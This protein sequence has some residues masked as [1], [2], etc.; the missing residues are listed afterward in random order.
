MRRRLFLSLNHFCERKKKSWSLAALKSLSMQTVSLFYYFD[1]IES[2]CDLQVSDFQT[3]QKST[4]TFFD[5]FVY[6]SSIDTDRFHAMICNIFKLFVQT[7]STFFHR[8]LDALVHNDCFLQH[9]TQNIDCVEHCLFNLWKRTVQFHDRID[10]T[11]CYYCDW[12]ES[13]ISN[14]FC[15]SNLSNC[16]R[17]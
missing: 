11:M 6:N 10:Q 2:N 1:F 5:I 17:C 9:Y 3:L 8:F 13:L 16:N 15:E 12:N 14:R 7:K 4:R